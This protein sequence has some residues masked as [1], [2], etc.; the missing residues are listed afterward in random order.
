MRPFVFLFS[1]FAVLAAEAQTIP[2]PTPPREAPPPAQPRTPPGSVV[3]TQSVPN[4][5]FEPRAASNQLAA[6]PAPASLSEVESLLINLQANIEQ[7]IPVLSGLANVQAGTT[8]NRP[9]NPQ[10]QQPGSYGSVGTNIFG[11]NANTRQL[12]I[13]LQAELAR[14]LPALRQLNGSAAQNLSGIGTVAPGGA[15]A[16]GSFISRFVQVTNA[17][18]QRILMPTGR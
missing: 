14:A 17:P 18:Q 16:P 1:L 3:A 10:L 15:N 7:A 4:V 13:I 11:M 6:V 5:G 8:V 2:Q 9:P 12:M